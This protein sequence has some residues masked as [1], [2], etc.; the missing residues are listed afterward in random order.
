MLQRRRELDL[1]EEPFRP[2]DGAELGVQDLERNEA[3]VTQIPREEDPWPSHLGPARARSRSEVRGRS[4]GGS[5]PP[6]SPRALNG[7]S[8]VSNLRRPSLAD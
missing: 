8:C 4:A 1:L 5:V 7:W 6:T 2:E 3:V